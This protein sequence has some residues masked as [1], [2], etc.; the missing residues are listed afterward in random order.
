MQ[1]LGKPDPTLA[2]RFECKYI[3]DPEVVPALRQY[4]EPFMEPDPYAA[5]APNYSYPICSLYLDSEDLHL[6]QQT[7]GGEKNRF[8]LRV[9]TYS[10]DPDGLAFFEVKRKFN[11]IVSKRRAAV[12]PSQAEEILKNG[13][14]GIADVRGDGSGLEFFEAHRRFTGAHP[15]IK[16]RYLREA[17]QSRGGD[18]V[19]VTLDTELMHCA[20]LGLDLTHERGRWVRTPVGGVILELKYT[21]LAPYWIHDVVRVFGLRQR[22]VPKYVMS[23]DHLLLRERPGAIAIAGI[24]LPPKA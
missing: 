22:P 13:P 6:Y 3:V 10:D 14:V 20:S 18:P 15:V 16:V 4:I 11:S 21:E 19:R 9:R 12:R 2:S 5:Y 23:L 7:V 1:T 24:T 17:Y 8:K